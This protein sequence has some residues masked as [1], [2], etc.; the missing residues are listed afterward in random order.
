[1]GEGVSLQVREYQSLLVKLEFRRK[2][3]H[4]GLP[5]YTYSKISKVDVIIRP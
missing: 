4:R 3:S 5:T 1:M 2:I